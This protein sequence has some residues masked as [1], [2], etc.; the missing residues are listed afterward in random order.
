MSEDSISR[1]Q[2]IAIICAPLSPVGLGGAPV[3]ANNTAHAPFIA[4]AFW[5]RDEAVAAGD[6]PY[7]AVVVLDAQI[8]GRGM[9][10]VTRDR[11]PDAHAERLALAHAQRALGRQTL[12]GAIVYSSARPCAICQRALAAARIARMIHGSDAIDSGAPAP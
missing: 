4:E 2:S 3:H 11:N 9:S 5:L 10:R 1:R 7:G 6:Q 12:D 8:V